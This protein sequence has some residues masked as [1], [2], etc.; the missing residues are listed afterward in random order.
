VKSSISCALASR[1][2][3]S[4]LTGSKPGSTTTQ[5]LGRLERQVADLHVDNAN[6]DQRI[7]RIE[8][9]LELAEA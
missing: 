7:S 9:R 4:G 6:L 8:R 3:T 5:R 2:W 1:G